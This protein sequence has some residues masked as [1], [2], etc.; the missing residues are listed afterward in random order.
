VNN[1][2]EILKTLKQSREFLSSE[3]SVK[4]IAVFGSVAR[5]AITPDSDVD[6]VVEFSTP[7]GFRFNQLV[8]YLENLL[9]RK[10]DVLT[11]DGIRN[12]RVQK[13]AENIERDLIYV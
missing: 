6:I 4:K 10:V 5:D 3:F 7:I 12:I 8:K 2:E 9:G 13:V 1:R 11:K